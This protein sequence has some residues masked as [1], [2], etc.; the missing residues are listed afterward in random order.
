MAVDAHSVPKRKSKSPI[1]VIAGMPEITR[2]IVIKKGI[3]NKYD[4][5][6]SFAC[7]SIIGKKKETAELFNKHITRTFGKYK[8]VYTRHEEGRKFI[9]KCRAKSYISYNAKKVNNKHKISRWE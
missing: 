7:P 6:Y 1:S 5:R 3:I 4:Y 2:Y 9:L 8:L